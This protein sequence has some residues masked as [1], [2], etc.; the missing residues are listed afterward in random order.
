MDLN[1]PPLLLRAQ[2]SSGLLVSFEE[3][4]L[5][6]LKEPGVTGQQAA[7]HPQVRLHLDQVQLC[8]DVG[9]VYGDS[10]G[11]VMVTAGDSQ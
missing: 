7:L 8:A 2:N 11:T 1:H 10:Q 5:M 3:K 4:T 9:E 6:P